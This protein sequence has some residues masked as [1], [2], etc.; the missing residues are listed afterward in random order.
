MAVN[1]RNSVFHKWFY[2]AD[3]RFCYSEESQRYNDARIAF[4]AGRKCGKLVMGSPFGEPGPPSV[5]EN[6]I[7]KSMI[8]LCIKKV[9]Y[10]FEEQG[11]PLINCME[12]KT[13]KA[14]LNLLMESK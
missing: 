10:K 9:E 13:L 8:R 5:E 2:E 11:G 6:I 7:A 14:A 12:W 1:S 3:S 4:E